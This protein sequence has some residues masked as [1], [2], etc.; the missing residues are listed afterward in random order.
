MKPLHHS[1]IFPHNKKLQKPLVLKART[2]MEGCWN[3]IVKETG[4]IDA[5]G[6][7]GWGT[8][9]FYWGEGGVEVKKSY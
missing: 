5:A 9:R 8:L 3:I 1:D 4:R 7:G 6:E 2:I